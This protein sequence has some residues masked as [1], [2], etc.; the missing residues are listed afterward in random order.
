MCLY[1]L[2]SRARTILWFI[3]KYAPIFCEDGTRGLNGSFLSTVEDV[4][5]QLYAYNRYSGRNF[6]TYVSVGRFNKNKLMKQLI[7]K[8]IDRYSN[9]ITINKRDNVK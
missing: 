3:D 4:L 2:D 6:S 8:L 7:K 9:F 1:T 5:L